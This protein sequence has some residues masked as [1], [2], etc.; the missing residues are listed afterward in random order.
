MIRFGDFKLT[1][2]TPLL[3]FGVLRS[4]VRPFSGGLKS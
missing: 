2:A 4:G 1:G 3:N